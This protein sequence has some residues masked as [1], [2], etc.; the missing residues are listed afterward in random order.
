[1]E[2]ND[3]VK[4]CTNINYYLNVEM[5]QVEQTEKKYPVVRLDD[6]TLYCVHYKSFEEVKQKWNERK[7]VFVGIMCSS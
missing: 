7:N 2:G 3:F 1:M 6:I 4:F 5:S